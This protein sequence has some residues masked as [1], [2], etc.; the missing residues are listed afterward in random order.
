MSEDELNSSLK[1]D[2]IK[3]DS[4]KRINEDEM[5]S[6]DG[7]DETKAKRKLHA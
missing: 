1:R 5:S 2:E 4:W 6:F 3:K 7:L